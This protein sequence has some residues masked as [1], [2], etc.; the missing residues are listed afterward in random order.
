MEDGSN[1]DPILESNKFLSGFAMERW[2]R[3]AIE[4][5]GMIGAIKKRKIHEIFRG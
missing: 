3:C 2:T 1:E 4:I 5:C